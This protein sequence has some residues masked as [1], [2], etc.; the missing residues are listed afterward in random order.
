MTGETALRERGRLLDELRQIVQSMKNLALAELQRL[1]RLK[2]AQAQA[3][4]ALEAAWQALPEMPEVSDEDMGRAASRTHPPKHIGLVI[5]AE[6]GFC[7]AFNAQ[8][9]RAAQVWLDE[10]PGAHLVAGSPR[11]AAQFEHQGS[12]TPTEPVTGLPGCGASEE[13]DTALDAWLAHLGPTLACERVTLWLLYMGH[14]G[15]RREQLW[16]APAQPLSARRSYTTPPLHYLPLPPLRLALRRQRLRLRLQA[17]LLNSLEQEN[18]WRLAQMQRAR[19]H[20][21]ELGE[22][23]R[24]RYASVR[25]TNITNELESLA[26]AENGLR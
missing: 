16:P 20:L 9:A 21:D 2:Q 18:H 23:L 17:A 24:R 14:D 26:G 22:G 6:R 15:V 12:G 4:E 1:A 10:T 25:Q 13:T 8:L 19:D 5:G 11:L 7:G 3:S